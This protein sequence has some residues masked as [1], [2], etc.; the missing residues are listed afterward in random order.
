MNLFS[1]NQNLTYLDLSSNLLT[2]IKR[3]DLTSLSKLYVLN[4]G[5]NKIS[6][7]AN[8]TFAGKKLDRAMRIFES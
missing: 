5:G 4:L 8:G 3:K 6:S 1:N 7:L 2:E